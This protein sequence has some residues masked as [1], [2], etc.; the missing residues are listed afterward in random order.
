MKNVRAVTFFLVALLTGTYAH[1]R[2]TAIKNRPN[3]ILIVMDTTRVDGISAFRTDG[4]EITPNIDRLARSGVMFTRALSNSNFTTISHMSLFT[5]LL[6]STHGV[7]SPD[8]PK[9]VL[10][11]EYKLLAEILRSNGYRTFWSGLNSTNHFNPWLGFSRG[12]DAFRQTEIAPP[13]LIKNEDSDNDNFAQ[14]QILEWILKDRDKPFFI[15]AHAW[16]PH[17]PYLSSAPQNQ[18]FL[19]PTYKG[20]LIADLDVFVRKLHSSDFELTSLSPLNPRYKKSKIFNTDMWK[21]L[22]FHDPVSRAYWSDLKED[23][24][25]KEAEFLRGAYFAAINRFDSAL[26]TVLDELK[27]LGALDNTLIVLTSDHGEE[28]FE[29]GNFYHQNLHNENLHI[30]LIFSGLGLKN[31][32]KNE[33]VSLIDIAPTILSILQIPTDQ[34]FDG[35]ALKMSDEQE[36]LDSSKVEVLSISADKSGTIQNSRWKVLYKRG[37]KTRVYDLAKDPGEL[38]PVSVLKEQK[39]EIEGMKRR[40]AA[41]LGTSVQ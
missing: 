27:K 36:S 39:Q 4:K 11:T 18:N 10:K 24:L 33:L 28:F 8:D 21:G 15:F 1:C 3:V 25:L 16:T 5:G 13:R 14:Q 40:L 41:R 26:G 32:K 37:Q 38:S 19:I 35:R 12:F 30:P 9:Q 17:A 22:M 31:K 34:Y 29:H 2:E 6:P 7:F 23:D 20:S